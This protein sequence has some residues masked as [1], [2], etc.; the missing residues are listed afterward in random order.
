MGEPV[1][2]EA[3]DAL[4][5][6]YLA[7]QEGAAGRAALSTLVSRW[8]ERVY[9]WAYRVVRERETAL[10]LAQESLM[11]MV[12]AL[13]RYEPRGRFSAWLFVIVHRRCLSG[14]RRRS[15]DVDHEIDGDSL[16]DRSASPESDHESAE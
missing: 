11:Q 12:E 8:S 2:D 14:V 3:D 10:D 7:N 1:A 4:I 13:P 5:A 16:W 9:R 15:L 6:E